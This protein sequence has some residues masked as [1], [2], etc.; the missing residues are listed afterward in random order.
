V[1]YRDNWYYQA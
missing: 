1:I